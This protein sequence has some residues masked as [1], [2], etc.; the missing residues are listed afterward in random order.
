MAL[1]RKSR[2]D[3]W[4][5]RNLDWILLA[6]IEIAL[7]GFVAVPF[8]R[9]NNLQKHDLI[10]HLASTAF[11]EAYL[12]PSVSGFNPFYFCGAPQNSLYPPLLAYLG[13][14]LGRQIGVKLALKLLIVAAVLATPATTYYCA[15]AHSLARLQSAVAALVVTAML[16]LDREELGGNFYSTFE[17]GNAANA[18]GLPL[19]LGY[20]GALAQ[21]R[22]SPKAIVLPTVLLA[23]NLLT[24]LVGGLVAL[25]LLGAHVAFSLLKDR[26]LRRTGTAFWG[27]LH[28]AWSLALASFFV[29]PM[30]AYRGFGSPDNRSYN[31]YPD[32]LMLVVLSSAAMIAWYA[33][34]RRERQE[35]GPLVGLCGLLLWGRNFLFNDLFPQGWGLH[36]H[37][38]KLYD[39]I[40]LLIVATW[41]IDGWLREWSARRRGALFGAI[42]LVVMLGLVVGL[43]GIDAR[44]VAEQASPRLPRLPSRVMVVSSP[45][46]QVSDHAMQHLVP[47]RTGNL[48]AKGLF[49]ETAANARFL[50]DLEMLLAA[51]PAQVRTWGVE[52][53]SMATLAPLRPDL[54]RMLAL[55]GFGYVL[56]NEPLHPDAGL[57]P[58]GDMGGGY[59]L[60]RA[61]YAELAEVW[62]GPIESVSGS[63]F[64]EESRRWF[65]GN[66][67]R[68]VVDFGPT[69]GNW[70]HFN[71][72]AISNAK[73][74]STQV[75]AKDQKVVVD[76]EAEDVVP[77][78]VKVT[79]APQFV[80]FDEAGKVLPSYRVSPNFILVVGRGRITVRY[81][82]TP[83]EHRAAILS[84]LAAILLLAA[85]VAATFHR[86]RHRHRG[87]SA[88][89]TQG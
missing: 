80:A 38:F 17:I 2:L 71:A 46:S 32:S 47:M 16:A 28:G 43:H 37:R 41:L 72:E 58:L 9:L 1:T 82:A 34:S 86:H 25:L 24:H 18:L 64:V 10:G 49:V 21:W 51:D 20:A 31:Q 19:F 77:V 59:T 14:L 35:I 42:L 4:G 83:L 11:T 69:R 75:S 63:K 5:L 76:V 48:V 6:S 44:G 33:T 30:F 23:L 56:A 7:L 78:L 54:R 3:E 29:V 53:D 60:Y 50:I 57:L 26:G 70:I 67:E 87:I 15:R 8:L 45:A 13:A 40:L 84:A 73:V 79:Y 68:L 39:G 36:V 81:L 65:F 85:A 66:H 12:Y 62:R 89:V 22:R 74:R 52:L 27:V 55:F 61:N 88:A